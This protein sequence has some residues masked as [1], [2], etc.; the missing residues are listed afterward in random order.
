MR[1]LLVVMALV[2][3]AQATEAPMFRQ[4]LIEACDQHTD[5][6]R[7]KQALACIKK[8]EK[9]ASSKELRFLFYSRLTSLI[10]S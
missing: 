7:H 5:K 9:S 3:A 4:Q 2:G 8:L 10:C 6:G 1:T